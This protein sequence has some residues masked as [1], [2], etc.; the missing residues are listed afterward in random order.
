MNPF[1]DV[2]AAIQFAAEKH[3][4]QTTKDGRPYI[5]HPIEVAYLLVEFGDIADPE[6]ISAA[7][8]H[9]VIEKCGVGREE[10]ANRFSGSIADVVAEL[11]DDKSL[12]EAERR[13]RQT[14]SAANLSR[15]A[16][17]IRIADKISNLKQ[18]K[19]RPNAESD[20]SLARYVEWTSGMLPMLSGVSPRLEALLM[21]TLAC[22]KEKT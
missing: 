18:L 19:N 22:A 14:A 21:E 8:L 11:S 4:G 17:V 3:A 16:K 6:I 9:D 5:N 1:A 7:I 2:F 20:D 12:P 15:R 10:L 13:L